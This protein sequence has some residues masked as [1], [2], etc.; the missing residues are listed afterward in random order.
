MALGFSLLA[1]DRDTANTTSYADT[2]TTTPA[3]NSA[4]LCFIYNTA[5]PGGAVSSVT[6][7]G[8][9]WAELATVSSSNGRLSVWWAYAGGSPSSSTATVAFAAN[10]TGC[11]FDIIEITGA[12]TSDFTVQQPTNSGTGTSGSVTLSA[13]GD[14][15]NNGCVAGF[16]ILA[17]EAMTE[18][19]TATWTERSDAGYNSPTTRLAV[20]TRTGEDTTASYSWTSSVA[21]AGIAVEIKAASGG[22]AT[23]TPSVVAVPLTLPTSVVTVEAAATAVAVPATLPQ[24]LV[25]VGAVPAVL[26]V[27]VTLPTATVAT[28]A[29]PAVV[30]V[31]VTLPE[32]AVTVAAVPALFTVVL[33]LPIATA[34]EGAADAT[35]TPAVI[36][37]PVTLPQTLA[38]VGAAPSLLSVPVTLPTAAVN[39]AALATVT[40]VPVTLPTALAGV[41][42]APSVTAVLLSLPTA[43]VGVVAA[44]QMLTVTV[45]LPTAT[46]GEASGFGSGFRQEPGMVATSRQSGAMI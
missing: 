14:A 12:D 6:A 40:T 9:T 46:A 21:W 42:A 4:L 44:P 39:V 19:A 31:P 15:T 36:A 27:P 2:E 13:F 22:A 10:Q 35:A 24:S 18:D 5:S 45:T 1:T 30:A 3:A 29:A 38:G 11:A 17:N 26:A 34:G 37:V 33:T 7:Y 28:V 16:G 20:A 41:G 32:P 43:T 25:T 23:A 8:A